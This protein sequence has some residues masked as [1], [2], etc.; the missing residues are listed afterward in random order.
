MQPCLGEGRPP[1]DPALG[2]WKPGHRDFQKKPGKERS[3]T[4]TCLKNKKINSK[5]DPDFDRILKAFGI[6]HH[7]SRDTIYRRCFYPE[8]IINCWVVLCL[9]I[10]ASPAEQRTLFISDAQQIKSTLCLLTIGSQLLFQTR[11]QKVVKWLTSFHKISQRR[12]NEESS[13]TL[14]CRGRLQVS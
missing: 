9:L 12:N 7:R 4:N 13:D 2:E 1:W 6:W 3:F 8:N 11:R 14:Y 5:V 10:L